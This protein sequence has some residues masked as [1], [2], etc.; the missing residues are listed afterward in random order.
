MVVKQC[1][2]LLSVLT[3]NS[4]KLLFPAKVTKSAD[5]VEIR[6]LNILGMLLWRKGS[7]ENVVGF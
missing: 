2:T 6:Y 7:S 3:I 4:S 5:T 1:P